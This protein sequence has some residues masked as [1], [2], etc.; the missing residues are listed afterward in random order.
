MTF[1]SFFMRKF[2]ICL[3]VLFICTEIYSSIK[4]NI[5]QFVLH[6][7]P[8]YLAQL[9]IF[10]PYLIIFNSIIL[11]RETA[12]LSKSMFVKEYLLPI[13]NVCNLNLRSLNETQSRLRN[14]GFYSIVIRPQQARQLQQLG[15]IG[16]NYDLT[17]CR[18]MLL[19]FDHLILLKNNINTRLFLTLASNKFLN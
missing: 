12:K 16:P 3:F 5:I 19:G 7:L 11:L 2:F 14:D 9:Y 1:I 10:H 13:I 8:M 15:Y 6:L 17:K 4:S 18:D